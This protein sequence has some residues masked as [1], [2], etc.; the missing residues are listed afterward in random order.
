MWSASPTWGRASV[1]KGRSRAGAETL[2]PPSHQM[3]DPPPPAQLSPVTL[4]PF[5]GSV[6][7]AHTHARSPASRPE[8]WVL[9]PLGPLALTLDPF[10]KQRTPG[11][12]SS[13]SLFSGCHTPWGLT[14]T[15]GSPKTL[16]CCPTV[17]PGPLPSPWLGGSTM[18]N[19]TCS[20]SPFYLASN[21]IGLPAPQLKPFSCWR[22]LSQGREGPA[23]SFS[24][25]A[26]CPEG[27]SGLTS[28]WPLAGPSSQRKAQEPLSSPRVEGRGSGA[29]FCQCQLQRVLS[30][31]YECSSMST[32]LGFPSDGLLTT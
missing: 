20:Q 22:A 19:S 14:P 29:W 8:S 26:L 5:L 24:C 28:L 25:L 31:E 13:R 27:Q 21:S 17:G 2:P 10:P 3:A 12:S 9:P 32:V 18:L 11:F 15:P 6:T 1:Q 4:F 16:P 30:P 7:P 23:A